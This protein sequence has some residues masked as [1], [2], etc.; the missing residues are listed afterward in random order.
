MYK[1]YHEIEPQGKR[2]HKIIFKAK[3]SKEY[4][5]WSELDEAVSNVLGS[6]WLFN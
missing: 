4:K 1:T 2:R 6:L 5:E 3:S